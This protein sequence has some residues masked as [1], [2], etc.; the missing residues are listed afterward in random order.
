MTGSS[1]P[2]S[3]TAAVIEDKGCI[4]IARRTSS[5]H[6]PGGWEF[7]GGKIEPGETAEECLI[8]EIYEELK[9]RIHILGPFLDYVHEYPGK[10]IRLISF[11]AQITDGIPV[12]ADHEELAWVAPDQLPGYTFLAADLPIVEAIRSFAL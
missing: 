10:S 1:P 12:P 11:K 7:P 4:L 2:V 8:R 9:I 5:S 6:G 3:V